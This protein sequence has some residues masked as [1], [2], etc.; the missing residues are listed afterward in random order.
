M[1]GNRFYYSDVGQTPKGVYIIHVL[2]RKRM[3]NETALQKRETEYRDIEH[4]ATRR[5]AG[6]WSDKSPTIMC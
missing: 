1:V 4:K 3:W 5:D 2:G 6:L